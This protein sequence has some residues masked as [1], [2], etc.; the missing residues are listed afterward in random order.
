MHHTFSA[1]SLYPD[2]EI[3]GFFDADSF[4]V[5]VHN[6]HHFDFN[7]N[8]YRGKALVDEGYGKELKHSSFIPNRDSTYYVDLSYVQGGEEHEVH[9]DFTF[10]SGHLDISLEM[11]DRV[12]PGQT[13]DALIKVCNHKG[14]PVKGVDLTAMASNSKL[15]YYVPSLPSYGKSSGAR[16]KEVS[17]SVYDFRVPDVVL[18]LDYVKFKAL[19]GLDTMK[20]YQFAYPQNT[21]FEYSYA[22]SDSTQ[23]APF[24]MKNVEMQEVFYIEVDREPVYYSW[25]DAPNPYSFYIEPDSLHEVKIRL[26]DRLLVLD[27]VCLAPNQKHIFSFTLSNPP[28]YVITSYSIHYTKLYEYQ[29]R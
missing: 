11:P 16:P 15:N 29:C 17:Y 12:Y 23:F 4:R 28:K 13:V 2:F 25:A 27:S 26:A 7:W 9:R 5:E 22:I 10:K 19:A 20:Y 3:N 6:P 14:Y 21:I 24:V 8:I 1:S 18:D